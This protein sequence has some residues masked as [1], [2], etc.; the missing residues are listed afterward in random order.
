MEYWCV[1]LPMSNLHK[2]CY[3]NAGR[4]LTKILE[5]RLEE[6]RT[7]IKNGKFGDWNGIVPAKVKEAA[8]MCPAMNRLIREFIFSVKFVRT[9][10]SSSYKRG[11]SR[12]VLDDPLI[13]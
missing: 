7:K 6:A 10:K 12:L 4:E 13:L 8:R 11:F 2:K 5:Q 9:L 3:L 1:D